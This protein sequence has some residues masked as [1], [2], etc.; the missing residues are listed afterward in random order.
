MRTPLLTMLFLLM[1]FASPCVASEWAT[2]RGRIVYDGTPPVPK[3]VKVDKDVEVCGKYDLY[4]ESLIVNPQ[5]RGLRDVVIRLTLGRGETLDIH[6]DYDKDAQGEVLLDNKCCRLEPHVTVMRTTQKLVIHNSDPKGDSIKID[7][8]KNNAINVTLPSGSQHVQEFPLVE[9]VPARVSCAI[10]PWELG[11]LVISDH[12]YVAVSD[13]DGNFEIKDIPVGKRSF[14][15]WQEKSGYLAEVTLQ[16]RTE[17]WR[18]GTKELDL[19]P[20][21]N[22]L[23]EI[24]VQPNL[25][26]D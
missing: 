10:H 22:D 19:Q 20:G 11:W 5:N 12:P 13:K 24:I 1:A 9:R 6:P 17:Q 4:D 21:I 16:G 26:A 7:P 2:L 25:F 14:M 23:G 8:L 3:R 15:F 18:R